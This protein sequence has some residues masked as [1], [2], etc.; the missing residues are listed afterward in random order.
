MSDVAAEQQA[1][2]PAPQAKPDLLVTS[3]FGDYEAGQRLTGEEADKVR[4]SHNQVHT[5]RV[6]PLSDEEQAA[7]KHDGKE[8]ETAP[9]PE[10]EPA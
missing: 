2:A 1:E 6:A 3:P 7:L 4:D 8:P 9:A 10:A 5:V